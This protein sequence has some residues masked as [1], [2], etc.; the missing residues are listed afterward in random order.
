MGLEQ[1]STEY[2][3]VFRMAGG[4]K[5][6]WEN[7]RTSTYFDTPAVWKP[8]RKRA[9]AIT[10]QGPALHALRESEAELKAE[11]VVT[12][13]IRTCARQ[14]ELYKSDPSRYAPPSVGLHC[15]GLAI[16][17]NTGHLNDRVKHALKRHGFTQAR[18]TDEP[19]H[20]SYGWTA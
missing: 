5:D 9:V 3:T 8:K 16:D 4:C 1:K 15:Q 10:L 7:I 14:A 19:W 11:I 13:S 6:D 12:G 20:F 17:V 18:P 2:G